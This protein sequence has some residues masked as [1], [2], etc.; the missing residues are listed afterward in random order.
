MK[1]RLRNHPW[2]DPGR[3]SLRNLYG[4]STNSLRILYEFSTNSLRILYEFS[5]TGG[6]LHVLI[7]EGLS[8]GLTNAQRTDVTYTKLRPTTNERGCIK[9]GALA[10]CWLTTTPRWKQ[11]F[12]ADDSK[13]HPHAC[14]MITLPCADF[15][16]EFSTNLRYINT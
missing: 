8:E 10:T 2:A 6:R 9:L 5:T 3:P 7:L 16:Y 4:F 13:R 14:R 12:Y 11:T 1:A 15:L